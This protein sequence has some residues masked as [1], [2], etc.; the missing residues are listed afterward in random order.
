MTDENNSDA[1]FSPILI[2]EFIRQVTVAHYLN[3]QPLDKAVRFKLAKTYYDEIVS[4][5]L[6][7]QFIRLCVEYDEAKEV[8]SVTA[9]EALINRFKE[10]KALV[11]IAKNYEAQYAERYKNFIEVVG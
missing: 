4:Y 7:V 2:M 6:Q 9:D 1:L 3:G 8:L 10:Q 11:E 5:E